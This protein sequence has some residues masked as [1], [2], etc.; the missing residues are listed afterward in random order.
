MAKE[1]INAKQ[2]TGMN[3][4]HTKNQTIYLNPLNKTA[5]IITNS[6]LDKWSAWSMRVP[7]CLFVTCMLIVIGINPII[8]L[9]IGL[10]GYVIIAILFYTKFLPSLAVNTNFKK[11]ASQGFIRDTAKRFE[12]SSLLFISICS[13]IFGFISLFNV[14][15]QS[16]E[17]VARNINLAFGL[18]F[19]VVAI[20]FGIITYIKKKENIK[21][22]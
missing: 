8:S 19:L 2:L 12:L 21:E 16:E 5:Y 3:I 6:V 7:G 15:R 17:L 13:L 22:N 18:V 1:S 11:P 14:F 10:I 9:V 20:F 4:Y